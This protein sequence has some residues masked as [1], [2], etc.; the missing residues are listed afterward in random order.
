MPVSPWIQFVR[1]SRGKFAAPTISARGKKLIE[2]Y[3]KLPVAAR[4]ALNKRAASR[5]YTQHKVAH[6]IRALG[7]RVGI[8]SSTVKQHWH[9]TTKSLSIAE[10]LK[11]VARK[12]NLTPRAPRAYR[13]PLHTLVSLPKRKAVPRSKKAGVSIKKGAIPV[14][15]VAPPKSSTAIVKAQ[16]KAH[17]STKKDTKTF[18]KKAALKSSTPKIV[19]V[20]KAA[21]KAN[22]VRATKKVNANKASA[23][24][25]KRK[26]VAARS[27][28]AAKR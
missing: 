23:A 25:K 14:P 17:T 7:R 8:P 4:A 27:K 11:E 6:R 10:R 2:A 13:R 5:Q 22:R 9:S 15:K 28:K 19:E 24:N 21:V 20:K 16:T 3:R 12:A 1:E 26:A 18:N